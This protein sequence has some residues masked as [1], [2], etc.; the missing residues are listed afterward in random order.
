[1]DNKSLI[2]I[3]TVVF[4]GEKYLEETIKSIINQTYKN[5]EYIII[6]GGSTDGTLDIIKKYEDKIDYWVSEPDKGIYDAMNKGIDVVRGEWINFMNAGDKFYDIN[7]L[8]KIFFQN[9]FKGIDLIYG[10]TD[11]GHKILKYKKY[12]ILKDMAQGMMICHQSAFYRSSND[13]KYNLVYGLC[14]DQD[15]TMQYLYKNNNSRYLERT[16]SK[17]NLDGISSQ[18][19]HKI[20][21]EKFRI[22]K[23]YKLSYVPIIKSYALSVLVRIRKLFRGY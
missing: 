16:I 9:D 22:N 2:S 7:I 21:K 18:S 20:T 17:Y 10:D 12:L 14:G 19:L 23:S 1:M 11:I 3:V 15:F 8:E 4:N 6:D 5:I 13:I